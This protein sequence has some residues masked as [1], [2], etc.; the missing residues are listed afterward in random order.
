[1][2]R[3]LPAG[4][5]LLLIARRLPH[6][7]WWWKSLVLGA[8][9]VGGFFVLI[10]VAGARLPSS[11]AAS[12][13]STSAAVM[14]LFAWL[15]LRQRPTLAATLGALSGIGGVALMM[16][17]GSGPVDAWGV[18]ASLGAMASSS[19]GF[20]LA[21]RWGSGLP[22][23]T[24]TA[25]QL[26]LGGL[27]IVPFAAGFEGAPPHLD[28]PAVLGFA[29]VTVIATALGYVV[30]FRGLQ[31]LP[32]ATVGMIGLLNPVTGVA[33]GVAFAGEVFGAPQV[34]GFVL[35]LTGVV[36]AAWPRRMKM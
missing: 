33:L 21:A 24:V 18:A 25:W 16:G 20:I 11:L 31:K 23:T 14:M 28:P 6:G 4:L 34:I 26:T 8:L 22:A 19:L 2:I 3:A 15:L 7:E 32:A 13:M 5:I 36:A 12:L 27:M 30:W 17:V 35:V 29:Y 10:F 1:M 9:N